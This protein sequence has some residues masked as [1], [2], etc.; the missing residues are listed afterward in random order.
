MTDLA[1]EYAGGLYELTEEEQLSAE[2]LSQ[3]QELLKCFRE[4]PAFLKLL[5]NMSLSKQERVAIVD[6]A[7]RGQIHPYL[8][9]F[10]KI[11]LERGALEEYAG[12]V[13]AFRT[14]YH[15]GHGFVDAQVTTSAPL[16]DDQRVKLME[17]LAQMTGS[18]IVLSEKVDP[19]VMGGVLLEMNGRRYD[20]T[21]RH[22]L[23]AIRE[24]MTA[25]A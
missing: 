21:V 16:T 17:R 3:M 4:E 14:L 22:R 13:S 25:E 12:C 19:A 18:Q 8:L 11:L 5:G 24:A 10:V 7:L 20:N 1:R 15:D 6:N 9:N 2:V 23:E